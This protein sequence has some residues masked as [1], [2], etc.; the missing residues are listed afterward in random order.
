MTQF[1]FF[2]GQIRP[3]ADAKISIMNHTFNYGTGCFAGIR[4]YWNEQQ[5]QLYVFRVVDHYRRFLQSAKLL[6]ADLNYSAEQLAAITVELLARESWRQNV[7]IRPLAY[8]AD[9]LIGVRLH[10]LH[11]AVAIFSVPMG[12]YIPAEEGARVGTS[13]WRRVD[14][15]SIPARGKLIGSYVNSAFAKTEA[16]LNGFD[17]AIVLNQD[18]HVS[19]GSA[20]NVCM[21]RDGVLI[22]PPVQSN[23]LEGITQRSLMQLAREELGLAVVERDIDRTELYIADE[24]FFCGTGVQIAAIISVDHRQVGSGLMGPITQQ[25]RDLYFRVVRGEEPKYLSWLTP[26]PQLVPA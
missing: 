19:E 1:A 25:L 24:L 17:E 22:T 7:Y 8:K 12:S 9:E 13:S 14:D 11:D 3:I 15:T 10:N 26:V 21:V 16:V 18:G 23:V 6:M 5:E 4:A 20:A 2:D